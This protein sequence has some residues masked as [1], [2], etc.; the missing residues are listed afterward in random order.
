MDVLRHLPLGTRMPARAVED[1]HDLLLGTSALRLGKGGQFGSEEGDVD[2]GGQM[3][4]HPPGG[5]MHEAD[6]RAPGGAML[7]G[8]ERSLSIEAPDLL[9]DR[10]QADPVFIY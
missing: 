7:D 3:E 4:D 10:F 8:R 5:R 6:E 1:E 9:Q 2:A